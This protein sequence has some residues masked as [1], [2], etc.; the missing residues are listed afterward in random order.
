MNYTASYDCRL[1][2]SQSTCNEMRQQELICCGVRI[3]ASYKDFSLESGILRKW[4][5]CSNARLQLNATAVFVEEGDAV[6][7][8]GLAEDDEGGVAGF[9]LAGL[10]F[11][12][13]A[14]ADG[15]V[16][17]QILLVPVEKAACGAALG[18]IDHEGI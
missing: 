1:R 7:F 15:G 13:G 8:E 6:G 12:D 11:P 10:E 17:G 2:D 4:H 9:G 5:V 16:L 14:V 3:S 18:G